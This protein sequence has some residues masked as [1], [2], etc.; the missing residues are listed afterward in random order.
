MN[1]PNSILADS[2]QGDLRPCDPASYRDVMGAF[3]TGVTVMTLGRADGFRLGVT[4][5]SFN[6]VSLDPPLIVW[7][8]AN[9]LPSRGLFEAC[10]Y[11]AINVLAEDQVDLSQRFA[12][13]LEDK[14]VGLE[15][16]TGVGGAPLLDGAVAVFECFNRSRYEE[17]D[18]V[19]FVG[20]VERCQHRA[21]A[22]PLLFHGGHLVFDDP[23]IKQG[24]KVLLFFGLAIG[25]ALGGDRTIGLDCNR[26]QTTFVRIPS[27]HGA[28]RVAQ[29]LRVNGGY[30]ILLGRLAHHIQR[31]AF[32]T[33]GARSL[34]QDQLLGREHLLPRTHSSKGGDFE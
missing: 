10:E 11:Y 17:G 27:V 25:L 1:I 7:S 24:V 33:C 9:D 15:Y 34:V 3:A 30:P 6:T 12:S 31:F 16:D 2:T 13:R 28:N 4:A 18:H 8:L 26:T 5:S 29:F 21:G 19:I 20:E 32:L 14:F 23:A 22:S